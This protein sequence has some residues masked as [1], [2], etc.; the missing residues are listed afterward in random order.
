[1]RTPVRDTDKAKLP[2]AEAWNIARRNF[3]R[4]DCRDL[5]SFFIV[6]KKRMKVTLHNK[7]QTEM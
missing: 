5:Q 4:D 1:M 7:N 6:S 2:A 3:G